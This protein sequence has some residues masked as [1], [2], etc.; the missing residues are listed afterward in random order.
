MNSGTIN[1]EL[2]LEALLRDRCAI[3][4][5]RFTISRCRGGDIHRSYRVDTSLPLDGHRAL[6]VKLN[7]LEYRPVIESEYHSLQI[8]A[9]EHEL[10]YPQ[11]LRIAADQALACLIMVY[12]DLAGIS[13]QPRSEVASAQLGRILAQQHRR[14]AG[15]FGWDQDNHIGLTAQHNRPSEDWLQFYHLQR[16]QPQ[17]ALACEQGLDQ[18]LADRVAKLAGSLKA[19][20]TDYQPVPSLLH[21]DLWSGNAG[22]DLNLGKPMLFDPAPYYG[23]R[24]ADIAMTELFGG[25]TNG[26][27][28]AYQNEWPLDPGYSKRKPLYNL[29]HALNH[30]NLFGKG[31]A[32]MVRS[33]LNELS[34]G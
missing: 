5:T 29:Y 14:S 21:G 27:Y 8:L 1:D 9:I 19:Y 20:F 18:T 30:F 22:Y 13:E 7:R 12:H 34:L 3:P 23:D 6:F 2:L 10:D 16:L 28:Q 32:T 11:P 25:F 4:Q 15:Y 26:F 17:L 24:E 33:L 31:Y